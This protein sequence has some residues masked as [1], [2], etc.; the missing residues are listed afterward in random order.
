M[1]AMK[2]FDRRRVLKATTGILA[3]LVVAGTPLAV[4]AKGR[5]WAIEL[6]AL[7]SEEAAKLVAMARTLFP[8][9]RL[10]DLA[11]AGVVRS[12]DE[13]SRKDD[14]L[15]K[16]LKAGVRS[17]P[18]NFA[19]LSEPERVSA[20][21][22]MEAGDF[23]QTMRLKTVQRLYASPMAYACFGYQGESFS[24]GGYLLRGFNDLHWLPEVPLED[25]G[26]MPLG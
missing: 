13:E 17:L 4:V 16:L 10:D 9:D 5:A 7:S 2:V 23:F 14:R 12:I 3:G 25:S 15:L 19:K 21:K 1:D 24:E 6:G 22:T 8:H 11:Y 20:L 18:D 26:P